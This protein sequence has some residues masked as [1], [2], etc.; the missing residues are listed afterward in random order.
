MMAA[1]IE[2]LGDRISARSV[3]Q[4]LA[5]IGMLFDWLI[6]SGFLRGNPASEVRGPKH[7]V[8]KGKTPVLSAEETRTLLD[9]LAVHG[10][11][12][13][14]TIR[15]SQLKGARQL[16]PA[17]KFYSLATYSNHDNGSCST[18]FKLCDRTIFCC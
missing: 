5:A 4:H 8:K 10:I 11:E 9:P 16:R 1:Y 6:V 18:V 13:M 3:K 17:Q 14:P 15:K 2:E 12:F 7:S